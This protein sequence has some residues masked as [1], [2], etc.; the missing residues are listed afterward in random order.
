MRS[1]RRTAKLSKT[2]LNNKIKLIAD[3]L[4]KGKGKE[5][6]SLPF[7]LCFIR[8]IKAIS[9]DEK[10]FYEKKADSF[11]NRLFTAPHKYFF[12]QS[13]PTISYRPAQTTDRPRKSFPRAIFA[14]LYPIF[15]IT[16][17]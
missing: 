4:S 1:L 3:S 15:R 17:S 8:K 9:S 16:F 14:F 2:N 5:S 10:N 13:P 6:Y 12:K 11:K 7:P